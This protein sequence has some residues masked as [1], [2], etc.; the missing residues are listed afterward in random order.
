MWKGVDDMSSK[1][2]TTVRDFDSF[3]NE[4][5]YKAASESIRKAHELL[6]EFIPDN[7]AYLKITKVFS[8]AYSEMIDA[9][10]NYLYIQGI[11]DAAEFKE[12]SKEKELKSNGKMEEILIQILD[13]LKSINQ[14]ISS[15][16]SGNLPDVVTVDDIRSFLGI[17][18]N[19]AYE[20][21]NKNNF[22]H[23]NLG[24]K[25]GIPKNEFLDW[26]E[27][28]KMRTRLGIRK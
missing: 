20:I 7:E 16:T 14:K 8:S 23:L 11:K 1:L 19:A 26:F 27:K 18:I 5:K 13:E 25:K 17:G 4:P 22:T 6:K 10:K 3:V 9:Y 12:I 2:N 24:R 21:I 15:K 28:E